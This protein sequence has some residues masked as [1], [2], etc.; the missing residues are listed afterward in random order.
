M[1]YRVYDIDYDTD[2]Q[3]VDLPESLVLTIDDGLDPSI[4]LADEISDET[5]WCVN[6]FQFERIKNED[7]PAI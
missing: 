7:K 6:S 3:A 5:G 2:G 1:E 4:Y